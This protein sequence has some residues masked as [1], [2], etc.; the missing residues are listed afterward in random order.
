MEPI[1]LAV[2][3]CGEHARKSHIEP[4]C[5]I[6]GFQITALC[7]A[8]V[9]YAT[10]V[11]SF[12]EAEGGGRDIVIFPPI[13]LENMLAG[14]LVD[15]V[16]IASPDRFHAAQLEIALEHG[17]H[18]LVEKPLA[19][20][21]KDM[22]RVIKALQ[23]EKLIVTSCHPRRFDPPYLAIKQALPAWTTDFG[24][25]LDVMLDFSYHAPS[26][27][28]L[29]AG[30]LIDHVSHEID[31]LNWLLGFSN[32]HARKQHD[33]QTRYKVDG[34]RLD[35]DVTFSFHGTRRLD[36][37][38]YPEFVRLRFERGTAE[39]WTSGHV[40][41]LDHVQGPRSFSPWPATD[42]ALRFRTLMENFRDAIRGECSIELTRRDLLMNSMIGMELTRSNEF[43][44][45]I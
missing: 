9:E 15:A 28:G 32:V 24:P 44:S 18:V 45:L 22:K 29:H 43:T 11:A 19:V 7:D 27:K 25:L 17:K 37:R 10:G 26:K 8:E 12:V 30:L 4:V 39:I 38:R 5:R 14:D 21:P 34:I 35:D 23:Q 2:I 40:T 31:L 16:V 1:R 3:G 20:T 36:D 33:E 6:P 41:V 13:K 42:Y